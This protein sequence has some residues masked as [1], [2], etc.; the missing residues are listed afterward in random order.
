[1]FCRKGRDEVEICSKKRVGI[2]SMIFGTVLI[3][4]RLK[5]RVI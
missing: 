5:Y 4:S 3:Q 2:S 1:M